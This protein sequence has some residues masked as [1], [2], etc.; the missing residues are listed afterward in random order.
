MLREIGLA[1]FLAA[2]GTDAG[3]KLVDVLNV[4]SLTI[5]AIG[6]IVAIAPMIISYVVGK[7]IMKIPFIPLMGIIAGALTS[8]LGLT[9]IG[10]KTK[11]ESL[12]ANYATA[13]PFALVLMIILPQILSILMK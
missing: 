1:M 11:S 6:C 12:Q 2:V 3:A 13:Y 5:V 7:H 10:V 8:T 9:I 4:R